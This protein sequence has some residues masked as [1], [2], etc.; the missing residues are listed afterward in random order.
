[1][2]WFGNGCSSGFVRNPVEELIEALTADTPTTLPTKRIRI[3]ISSSGNIQVYAGSER[4]A[5]QLENK[6]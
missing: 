2:D 1:M 6:R 4:L 3:P 5:K